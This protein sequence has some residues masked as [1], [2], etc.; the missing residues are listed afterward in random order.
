MFLIFTNAG[1]VDSWQWQFREAVHRDPDWYFNALNGPVASWITPARLAEQRRLLPG[2]AFER[3]WLNVWSKGSGTAL[4]EADIDAAITQDGPMRGDEVGW[5]F[6]SA[7]DIGISHDATAHVVLGIHTGHTETIDAPPR[8]TTHINR[9]LID[10]GLIQPARRDEPQQQIHHAGTGRVRLA[11]VDVWQPTNGSR[12]DL[13]EV[14]AAIVAANERFNLSCVACDPWQSELMVQ[15]LQRRGLAIFSLQQHGQSLQAQASA[16]L[17]VFRERS[18]ELFRH[19]ALIGDLR[20]LQVAE[21]LYGFRLISP[22]T[23]NMNTNATAHGDCA[24]AFSIGL[25]ARADAYFVPHVK[26]QAGLYAG[27]RP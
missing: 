24:T 7:L 12:V 19:D 8:K 20:S 26:F 6:C 15:R 10:A 22:K 23:S 25:L 4:A 17:D 27:L 16:V 1:A 13:S 2:I 9:C 21:R 14:E 5:S 11:H 18:I 3:L